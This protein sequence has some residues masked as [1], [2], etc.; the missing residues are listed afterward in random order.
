MRPNKGKM[1]LLYEGPGVTNA[2]GF[3]AWGIRTE[4]LEDLLA[5]ELA[6]RHPCRVQTSKSRWRS[7]SGDA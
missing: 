3:V 6:Q 4:V 1:L 5:E 2:G 7:L